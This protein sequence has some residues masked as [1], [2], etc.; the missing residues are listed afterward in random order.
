[1]AWRRPA[2]LALELC[3][4]AVVAGAA[5]L[6]VGLPTLRLRGDYLAIATL[7]FGEIIRVAITNCQALGRATGMTVTPYSDFNPDTGPRRILYR[8]GYWPW[9]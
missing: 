1:M 7:G 8:A 2:A 6:L 3:M 5:G 4:A 9:R